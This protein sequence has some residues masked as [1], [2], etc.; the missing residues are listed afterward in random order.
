MDYDD[1]ERAGQKLDAYIRHAQRIVNR[2]EGNI[3]QL[4]IGDKGSFFY[5]V[6]GA[7][8]AHDDDP[9]RAVQAALEL[10][11]PVIASRAAAKQ[12]PTS[13]AEIASSHEPLLAMTTHI[14]IAAGQMRVGAYGGAARRAYGAL[15]DATNLAARL[16]QAAPAGEIRCDDNVYRAARKRLAFE[17][18]PPIRVKGKAGLIRVYKPLSGQPSFVLRPPSSDATRKSRKSNKRWTRCN[19]ARRVCSSSK[20]KRASANRRSGSADRACANKR[21]EFPGRGRASL[22]KVTHRNKRLGRRYPTRAGS[23]SRGRVGARP[24]AVRGRQNRMGARTRASRRI[25]VCARTSDRSIGAGR[26]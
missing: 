22:G 15:G 19:A 16:M 9:A 2:Y 12:S 8:L 17:T 5:A 4:T 7:S 18:L 11:P 20:A 6:F 14:G 26:C 24:C 13:D 25:C 21:R 23:A 3:I 1:D 10:F